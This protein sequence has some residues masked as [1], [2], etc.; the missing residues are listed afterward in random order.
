MNNNLIRFHARYGTEDTNSKVFGSLSSPG[1]YFS[2]NSIAKDI[3]TKYP[4]VPGHHVNHPS[5]AVRKLVAQ[6]GKPEHQEQLIHDPAAHV[7]SSVAYHGTPEIR[8]KMLNDPSEWTRAMIAAH[9]EH[10]DTLVHDPHEKVQKYVARHGEP[11]HRAILAKSPHES[12]RAEVAQHTH[13]PAILAHLATDKSPE[14][15]YHV[16]QSWHTSDSDRQKLMSDENEHVA[17]NAKE[18]HQD[19]QEYLKQY[20]H[21]KAP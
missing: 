19:K 7:R 20:G 8:T 16:A 5:D 10:L 2:N 14:V 15:R 17:Q 1:T 12:V 4:D 18:T 3:A 21:T 11:E 9:G 6:Y 13:E